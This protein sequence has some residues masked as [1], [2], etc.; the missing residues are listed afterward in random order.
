[1][2]GHF[3][4]SDIILRGNKVKAKLLA[5]ENIEDEAYEYILQLERQLMSAH[6]AIRD[7]QV[8]CDKYKCRANESTKEILENVWNH[9]F[10][11]KQL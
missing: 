1:M 11:G 4:P 7:I 5:T 6:N 2:N 3:T 9:V 10:E 8:I